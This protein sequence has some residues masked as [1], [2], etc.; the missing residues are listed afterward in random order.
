MHPTDIVHD[1]QV[2]ELIPYGH[3]AFRA[4]LR[5]AVTAKLTLQVWLN[6][7]GWR[8]RYAYQLDRQGQ[9]ILRWATLPTIQSRGPIFHT[10]STTNSA[11]YLHPLW[12]EIRSAIFPSC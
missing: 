8:T 11:G 2:I 10:T 1:E 3:N 5:A 12:S 4:K 6:H 7:N 9:P